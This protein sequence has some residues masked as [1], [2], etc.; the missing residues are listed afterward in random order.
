MLLPSFIIFFA[1]CVALLTGLVGWFDVFFH[2]SPNSIDD[3]WK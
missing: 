3:G 1:F 2:R